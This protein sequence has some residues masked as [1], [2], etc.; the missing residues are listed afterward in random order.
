MAI[1]TSYSDDITRNK[2]GYLAAVTK[3]DFFTP[4]VYMSFFPA[5]QTL[6]MLDYLIDS[7]GVTLG[8]AQILIFPM[9]KTNFGPPLRCMADAPLLYHMRLYCKKPHEGST[10][11]LNM[12][13]LNQND[14][15][16][17]TQSEGGKSTFRFR[18]C[19]QV[20]RSRS[21]LAR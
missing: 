20:P 11:H 10:D 16:P 19:S 2:K 18:H 3:G 13:S 6:S 8:A 21:S 7:P 4:H 17:R 1:T 9:I 15:L 14:F 12:L 5:D